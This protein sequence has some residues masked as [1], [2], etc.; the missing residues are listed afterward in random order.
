MGSPAVKIWKAGE[1]K[2]LVPKNTVT[3]KYSVLLDFGEAWKSVKV[4][5]DFPGRK[6]KKAVE[7]YEIELLK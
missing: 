7:L 1:L 4:R 6:E 3:E 2:D 5:I